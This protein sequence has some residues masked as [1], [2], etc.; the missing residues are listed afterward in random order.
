[1]MV[2][3]MWALTDFTAANGGTRFVPGL[4]PLVRRCPTPRADWSTST[5]ARSR[6]RPAA[7]MIFHGSLWH[8]G[9]AEHDAP[10]SGGSA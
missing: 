5:C 1:M 7:V 8:G 10:T 3:S 6:C 4:A 9:G 2:T